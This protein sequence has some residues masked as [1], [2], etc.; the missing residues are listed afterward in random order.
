MPVF[1]AKPPKGS[2]F[3]RGDPLAKYLVAA[4]LLHGADISDA[5]GRNVTGT[6][7][8]GPVSEPG[9]Y[10]R[11]LAFDGSNDYT[12]SPLAEAD[13]STGF[14]ISVRLKGTLAAGSGGSA[15]YVLG[16]GGTG[17]NIAIAWT[18]SNGSYDGSVFMGGGGPFPVVKWTTPPAA[19]T[20]ATVAMTWDGATITAYV[21]GVLQG[22][23][24]K[25][26]F[27]TVTTP[28]LR[29]GTYANSIAHWGGTIDNVLVWSRPL[30]AKSI[31]DIHA[32]PLRMFRRRPL[33]A[34]SAAPA[35]TTASLFAFAAGW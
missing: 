34:A 4:Y 19:N 28:V 32:D 35:P 21:D 15:R 16:Y 10:G 20:W 33:L 2:L 9:P 5:T 17:D 27:G 7:F 13:V 24:A 26:V 3:Q 6:I 14:T 30:P 22:T 23:V 29:L 12:E 25:P 11:A 18:H 31:M 1:P 8:N